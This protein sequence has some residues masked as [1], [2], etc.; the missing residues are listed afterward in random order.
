[1]YQSILLGG[2]VLNCYDPIAHEAVIAREFRG[3]AELLNPQTQA[4]QP[5]LLPFVDPEQANPSDRCQRESYF[6]QARLVLDPSC[7]P[8]TCVNVNA[9]SIYQSSPLRLNSMI[10]KYCLPTRGTQ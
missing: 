4:L 3:R 6:T 5:G 8:G 7:T 9:L 1:M 2:A 10:G